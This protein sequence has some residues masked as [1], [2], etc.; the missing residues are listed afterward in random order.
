MK[1]KGVKMEPELGPRVAS[2]LLGSLAAFVLGTILFVVLAGALDIN[3]N[4]P[5]VDIWLGFFMFSFLGFILLL[6]IH[7]G[8]SLDPKYF[9]YWCFGW[10]GGTCFSM[11]ASFLYGFTYVGILACLSML[12]LTGNYLINLIWLPA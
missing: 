6:G 3:G 9:H 2:S 11:R 1:N 4:L 5:V 7:L 12:V 8:H 10:N